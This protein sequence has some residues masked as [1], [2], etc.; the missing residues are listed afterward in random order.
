MPKRVN[1]DSD[2]IAE[3][4]CYILEDE[5]IAHVGC[6]PMLKGIARRARK[7]DSFPGNLFRSQRERATTG[8]TK[9]GKRRQKALFVIWKIRPNTSG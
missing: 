4:F 6:F 3:A 2:N 8:F 9:G 5:K 1:G 7:I